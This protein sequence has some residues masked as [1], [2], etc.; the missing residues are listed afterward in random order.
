MREN[1]KQELSNKPGYRMKNL[2]F[3]TVLGCLIV[4]LAGCSMCCG[5]FDF[6]YPTYGGFYQRAERDRGRV[7]SVYS[8]PDYVAT[9]PSA[10]SN[11]DPIDKGSLMGFPE[12]DFMDELD[13][14]DEGNLPAP[15]TDRDNNRSG[16][17]PD[18][19]TT[20]AGQRQIWPITFSNKN[21]R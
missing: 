11:L 16:P 14:G 21:W 4:T 15:K 18:D 13:P 7:G 9:G 8:D 6:S 5:P 1:R 2:V 17:V 3:N 19:S 20:S 10:D 12:D